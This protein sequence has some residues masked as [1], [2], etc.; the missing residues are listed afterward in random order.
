MRLQ[1]EVTDPDVTIKLTEHMVVPSD[2][3]AVVTPDFWP[4]RTPLVVRAS[5]EPS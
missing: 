1:A 4:D 3:L 2:T 5:W